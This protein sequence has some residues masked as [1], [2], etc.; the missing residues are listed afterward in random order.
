VPGDGLGGMFDR[1]AL[2]RE[3]PETYPNDEFIG[4]GY[5][6]KAVADPKSSHGS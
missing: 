1:T 3:P 2:A 4:A 5:L 6:A